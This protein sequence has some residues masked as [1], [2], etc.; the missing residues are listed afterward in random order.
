MVGPTEAA[1]AKN[2][3]FDT[4]EYMAS[5]LSTLAQDFGVHNRHGQ[6]QHAALASRLLC[7]G[8]VVVGLNKTWTDALTN[9]DDTVNLLADRIDRAWR[10]APKGFRKTLTLEAGLGMGT[11]DVVFRTRV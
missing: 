8:G 1:A 9:T 7:T 4:T 11:G 5:T 2:L 10:S 6:L 3:A